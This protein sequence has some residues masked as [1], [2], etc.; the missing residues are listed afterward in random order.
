MSAKNH[1]AKRWFISG[2]VHGVGFRY[3]VRHHAR[4]LNVTGWAKNLSDGRVE[5]LAMGPPGGLSE[6]A[7]ALHKGPPMS[8]VRSVEEQEATPESYTDFHIR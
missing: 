5:V 8:Q 2:I 4:I 7:A 6:L 3:F 1:Q